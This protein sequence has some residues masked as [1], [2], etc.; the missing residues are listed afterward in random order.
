MYKQGAVPQIPMFPTLLHGDKKHKQENLENS[1]AKP[2]K[3][4]RKIEGS[5]L[6]KAESEKLH[7]GY[8]LTL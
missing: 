7:N 6:K 2:G 5:C 8:P 3:Y 1:Q 4:R